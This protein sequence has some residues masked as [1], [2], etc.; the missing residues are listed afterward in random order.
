LNAIEPEL[1][2]IV[3]GPPPEF[4]AMPDIWPLSVY[5][6]RAPRETALVQMRTFNGPR[7][8]E[9]CQRAW[10]ESRPVKL[11]YPDGVGAR[12]QVDV[13]AARWGEV[14]EGHVLYLWVRVHELSPDQRDDTDL[15]SDA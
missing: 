4:R 11:D 5:E 2:T 3:E 1:I 14:E 6:A 12:G 8:V 15:L 10:V 13:V 7:L 9:R